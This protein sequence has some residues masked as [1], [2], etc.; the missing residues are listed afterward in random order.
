MATAIPE[1]KEAGFRN[2]ERA[3]KLLD[4]ILEKCEGKK[5]LRITPGYTYLA[6]RSG[7]ARGGIG[8]YLARLFTG[9]FVNLRLGTDGE[10]TAIELVLRN[11]NTSIQDGEGVQVVQNWN[12][13]R[14]YRGD[15]A[16]INSH[17]AYSSTRTKAALP[18]LGDNGLGALMALL[19][20]PMTISEA[21]EEVGYTY[22]AMARSL[23]RFAEHALVEVTHGERNRKTY[24]LKGAWRAI[25]NTNRP[26]MPTYA[27]M[28][29][30]DVGAWK[31]RVKYLRAM[32]EDAQA[33]R[34]EQEHK[35]L[36]AIGAKVKETAGIIPFERPERIDKHALHLARVR[37]IGRIGERAMHR[38]PRRSQDDRAWIQS[39]KYSELLAMCGNQW[40]EFNAWSLMRS[41][42]G[43]WKALDPVAIV[44]LFKSYQLDCALLPLWTRQEV[45]A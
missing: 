2:A 34:A 28:L 38:Q 25:L 35:R 37:S 8:A 31:G 44:D 41:G 29:L 43:W 36:A 23:R 15:E 19:D 3:R 12:I 40:E 45:A 30:R 22:G 21:A 16:F 5:S 27:V 24:T 9:G 4:T 7:I 39:E 1:L 6:K 32:G 18:A 14:E 17:Y 13:Y 42:D 33:E 20:G 10:T 11:L 26:Q